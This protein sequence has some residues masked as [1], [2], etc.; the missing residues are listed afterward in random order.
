MGDGKRL[1]FYHDSWVGESSLR[2]LDYI[3][4]NG[5]R[6]RLWCDLGS[7]FPTKEVWGP[8]VLTKVSFFAWETI[9]KRIL[10]MDQIRKVGWSLANLYRLFRSIEELSNH[11]FAAVWMEACGICYPLYLVFVGLSLIS[12]RG[13]IELAWEFL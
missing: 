13:T 5:T 4:E 2:D 3:A 11:I 7:L 9:R 12:E 8:Y 1:R 10:T 6:V